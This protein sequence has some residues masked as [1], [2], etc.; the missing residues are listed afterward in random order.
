M[1][2]IPR[3]ADLPVGSVVRPPKGATVT[4]DRPGPSGWWRAPEGYYTD[5]EDDAMLNDGAGRCAAGR[6]LDRL[7]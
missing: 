5:S 2:D 4:R 7:D 6:F 1:T 3:A